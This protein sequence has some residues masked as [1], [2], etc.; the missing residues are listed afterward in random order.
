MTFLPTD[1]GDAGVSGGLNSQP[2]MLTAPS[3][4]TKPSLAARRP[5]STVH[6]PDAHRAAVVRVPVTQ[7]GQIQTDRAAAN[8]G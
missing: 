5:Q 4:V 1:T 8:V 3:N 7:Y 2:N 6:T